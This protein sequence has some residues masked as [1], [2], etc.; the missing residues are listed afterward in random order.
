MVRASQP[1]GI[2]SGAARG[3]VRALKGKRGEY[4]LGLNSLGKVIAP[5]LYT[6]L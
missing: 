2:R 4:I 3:R 5:H 6:Y 1:E